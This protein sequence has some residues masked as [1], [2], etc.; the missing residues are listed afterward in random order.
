MTAEEIKD[1]DL[2]F[3]NVDFGGASNIDVL[4]EGLWKSAC[5]YYNGFT[6]TRILLQLGL[7]EKRENSYPL[8]KKGLDWL[9][10]LNQQ[11]KAVDLEKV[12]KYL[13][14]VSDECGYDRNESDLNAVLAIARV[15]C[16]PY[17][18]QQKKST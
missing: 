10:R 7:T 1:V 12:F 17:L 11:A 6:I 14:Q 4:K 8:S 16:T 5:G 15:Q 9:L 2:A 13:E 18:N 3:K